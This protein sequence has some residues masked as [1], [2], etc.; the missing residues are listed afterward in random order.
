MAAVCIYMNSLMPTRSKLSDWKPP[1]TRLD[2]ALE[3]WE[4]KIG[5]GG[6]EGGGTVLFLYN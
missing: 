6:G 5:A 4:L 1:F 2:K 3:H